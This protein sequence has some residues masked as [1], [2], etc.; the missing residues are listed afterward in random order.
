MRT[1]MERRSSRRSK[2]EKIIKKIGQEWVRINHKQIPLLSHNYN[3]FW[4]FTTFFGI[5]IFSANTI[6]SSKRQE[7]H[8]SPFFFWLYFLKKNKSKKEGKWVQILDLFFVIRKI[9]KNWYKKI[10]KRKRSIQLTV[11]F[12]TGENSRDETFWIPS[13]CQPYIYFFKWLMKNRRKAVTMNLLMRC[14]I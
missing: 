3:S 14:V 1:G 11:G 6:F 13:N 10:W 2:W 7:K 4:N 12:C 9:H 8:I 5:L